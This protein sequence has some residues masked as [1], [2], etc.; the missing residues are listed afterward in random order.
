MKTYLV[1]VGYRDYK[2]LHKFVV[3][4]ENK[5][6]ALKKAKDMVLEMNK[7]NNFLSYNI[8]TIKIEKKLQKKRFLKLAKIKF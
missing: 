4:A 6:F 1:S 5:N 8:E 2:V 3:S 7:T